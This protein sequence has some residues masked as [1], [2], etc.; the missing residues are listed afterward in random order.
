MVKKVHHAMPAAVVLTI[1]LMSLMSLKDSQAVDVPVA[2]VHAT[3][4]AVMDARMVLLIVRIVP[5]T[6]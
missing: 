4:V 5:K 1:S 6:L 3:A 2:F